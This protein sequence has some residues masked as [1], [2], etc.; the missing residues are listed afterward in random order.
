MF[1]EDPFI[2]I[3]DLFSQLSGRRTTSYSRGAQAQNLLSTIETKKETFLLFDLSG[4][5]VISTK[6]KDDIETNEYGERVHNGQK[7]L[8]IKTNENETLKYTLPVSLSR[9]K[10]NYTFTN[11]IL[12]VSFKK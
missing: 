9:R 3:D 2:G 7:I 8:L 11:G 12:E 4:Q 5:K 6:I 1:G 10:I